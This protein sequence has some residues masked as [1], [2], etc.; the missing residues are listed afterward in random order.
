MATLTLTLDDETKTMIKADAKALNMN[1]SGYVST[2]LRAVHSTASSD[3]MQ[4][5]TQ[6]MAASVMKGLQ[7]K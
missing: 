3:G 6:T 7:E 2:I 5:L 4:E 1:V